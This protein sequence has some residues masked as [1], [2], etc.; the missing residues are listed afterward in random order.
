MCV[1][2]P[3][4][5]ELVT[6]RSSRPDAG[7]VCAA[8]ADHMASQKERHSRDSDK[9]LF[10]L[11]TQW[12]DADL[13]RIKAAS[14][15]ACA[16]SDEERAAAQTLR[17]EAQMALSALPADVRAAAMVHERYGLLAKRM[18][19][20]S[21]ADRVDVVAQEEAEKRFDILKT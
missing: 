20:A 6:R 9:R 15:L 2:V 3:K 1:R 17:I 4:F 10:L 12:C 19:K 14:A 11:A 18:N 7:R 5:K 13:A 21:A 16:R 8:I